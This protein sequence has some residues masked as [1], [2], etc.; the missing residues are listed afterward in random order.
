MRAMAHIKLDKY[1]LLNN[2]SQIEKQTRSI[3]KIAVVLKDNAYGHGIIQTARMCLEYGIH[4]AVVRNEREA[5][6]LPCGFETVLILSPTFD[7]PLKLHY[8]AAINSLEALQ[9]CKPHTNVELKVDTGMHRNGLTISQLKEAMTT[10]IDNKL[11][12]VGVFTHHKSSDSLNSWFFVQEYHFKAVIAATK[13]LTTRYNI[14]TPRF[15][16]LNSAGVFRTTQHHDIVR[17]GIALYGLLRLPQSFN[18]P[19]LRP[20]LSLWADKIATRTLKKGQTVGYDGTFKAPD[21]M[22]VSTYDVGYGDG[23]LRLNDTQSF[24]LPNGAPVLG[25]ISMDNISIASNEASVCI[26]DNAHDYAVAAHTIA[27]EVIT[28]LKEHIPRTVVTK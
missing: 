25:R 14:P 27:Y 10:I 6:L 24:T 16:S 11:N 3:K 21:D 13:E 4:H 8:H 15:H 2:L 1:A 7:V 22:L 17:V 20:V 18:T 23:L 26:F 28:H 19:T 5:E 12:L 9:K